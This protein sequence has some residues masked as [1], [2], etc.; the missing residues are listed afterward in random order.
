MLTSPE[1]R[2][3]DT[4]TAA[5]GAVL[6]RMREEG[7]VTGWRDELYPV[8]TSFGDDPALLVERAAASRFGVMVRPY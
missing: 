4:R 1:L 2:T 7:V 5:V 6:Q 8:M 3:T